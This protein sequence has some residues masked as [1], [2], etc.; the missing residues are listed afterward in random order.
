MKTLLAL[1]AALA[2]TACADLPVAPSARPPPPPQRAPTY[3]DGALQ[4]PGAV[5]SPSGMVLVPILEGTGP[6]PRPRDTVKVNY[7]GRLE[8]GTVFDSS[9]SHGGPTEFRVDKV[10]P[11]WTEGLQRMKV[12]GKARLVCPPSIAYGERGVPG[13]IPPDATLD[14]EVELVEIVK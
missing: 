4:L 10:V 7:R 1:A 13:S 9:E 11:C 5:R 12:G 3:A 6:S 2:A 14:F 8:D